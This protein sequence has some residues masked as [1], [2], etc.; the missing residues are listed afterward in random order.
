MMLSRPVDQHVK[1]DTGHQ[2]V[3][4]QGPL[5]SLKKSVITMEVDG[6]VQVSLEIVLENR[7]KIVLH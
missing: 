1:H 3:S 4:A 6:W 2:M 5:Q 7:P